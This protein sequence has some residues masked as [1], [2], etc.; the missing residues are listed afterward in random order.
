MLGEVEGAV[1]GLR[2]GPMGGGGVGRCRRCSANRARGCRCGARGAKL[3]GGGQMW[4]F[5]GVSMERRGQIWGE[6]RGFGAW[7][8]NVGGRGELWGRCGALPGGAPSSRCYGNALLTAASFVAM[9]T[10]ARLLSCCYGSTCQSNPSLWQPALPPPSRLLWQPASSPSPPQTTP[11]FFP[12]FSIF[13]AI[14]IPQTP[15]FP[16][17]GSFTSPPQTPLPAA[18]GWGLGGAAS[19]CPISPAP[20]GA[21]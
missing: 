18:G 3:R 20:W 9:A 19:F 14:F 2:L 12:F 11:H 17:R 10:P 21:E 15:P 16:P 7:G 6:R 8:C 1:I 4:G 5:G 13:L